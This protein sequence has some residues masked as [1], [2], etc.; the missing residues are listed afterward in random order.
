LVYPPEVLVESLVMF[1]A[2]L[3]NLQDFHPC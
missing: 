3:M 1:W 2:L